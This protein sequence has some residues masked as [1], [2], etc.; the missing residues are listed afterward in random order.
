[1][2]VLRWNGHG[3]RGWRDL[4][5]TH[6]FGVE[7]SDSHLKHAVL[8]PQQQFLIAACS[9]KISK[10]T[11][12]LVY[13]GP[14]AGLNS[15]NGVDSGD[16]KLIFSSGERH[17]VKQVFYRD[18]GTTEFYEAN[19]TPTITSADIEGLEGSAKLVTHLQR[20]RDPSLVRAKM[21]QV[22]GL[23]NKL[24]CEACGFNFERIYGALGKGF[25]E[26][27]HRDQL[28]MAGVRTTTLDAL[29][30]MCANCH[31]MIHRTDPMMSVETFASQYLSGRH[32]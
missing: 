5:P 22:L 26:V 19:I 29:A 14:H 10:R 23:R 2:L 16:M 18:E 15:R 25:C 32:G 13:G 1:M 3:I 9:I 12:T 11:A 31:R 4:V 27:H 21:E 17:D 24:E 20:E 8:G 30:V 28:A 6:W 7:G